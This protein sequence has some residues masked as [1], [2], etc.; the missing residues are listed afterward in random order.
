MAMRLLDYAARGAIALILI[1]TLWFKFRAAPESVA[2]FSALHVE[3][4]GRILAGLA[5][6][7]I[8]LLILFPRTA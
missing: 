6:L 5:E 8:S 3:P 1:Q 2:I 4:W 7:A